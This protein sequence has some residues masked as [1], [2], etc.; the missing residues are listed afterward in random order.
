[1]LSYVLSGILDSLFRATQLNVKYLL[2]ALSTDAA[3]IKY[4]DK[5]LALTTHSGVYAAQWPKVN[6][7]PRTAVFVRECYQ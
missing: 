2:L 1:V 7:V 6:T 4:C 3:S 5:P